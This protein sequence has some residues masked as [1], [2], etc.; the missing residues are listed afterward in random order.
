MTKN[1]L[2]AKIAK[3]C[4]LSKAHATAALESVLDGVA[5]ALK[6]G[7]RV[8]IPGFGSFAPSPSRPSKNR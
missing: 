1:E 2:V 5:K 6:R 4:G 7:E 3:D 8:T